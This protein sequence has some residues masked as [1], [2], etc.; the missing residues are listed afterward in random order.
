M[1]LMDLLE[2]QISVEEIRIDFIYPDLDQ[3]RKCFDLE[4]IANL[5]DSIRSSG[6]IKPMLV[7]RIPI[8][9]HCE[10][11]DSSQVR[12]MLGTF[13]KRHGEEFY[14]STGLKRCLDRD[15]VYLIIDGHRRF[16]AHWRAASSSPR[17][18]S[19]LASAAHSAWRSSW[20]PTRRNLFP[21]I[22]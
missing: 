10:G 3:P 14:Q 1:G 12:A 13:D 22:R 17:V 7:E 9:R 19:S 6:L 4:S 5:S 21:L 20:P 2:S 18:R 15:D 8:E 11:K 16:E